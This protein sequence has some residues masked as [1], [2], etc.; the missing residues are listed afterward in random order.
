MLNDKFLFSYKDKYGEFIQCTDNEAK[1]VY[2]VS[3]KKVFTL[4]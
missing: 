3:M 4:F 1:S 2:I